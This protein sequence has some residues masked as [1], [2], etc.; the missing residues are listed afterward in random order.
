MGLDASVQN[1]A[2]TVN[3]SATAACT[4]VAPT[5]GN[6]VYPLTLRVV[7]SAGAPAVAE[8]LVNVARNQTPTL[9]NYADAMVGLNGMVQVT[10]SAPPADGND[11]FDAMMVE[12]A[13]LPN[14]GTVAVDPSGVV[15][16][17]AGASTPLG[18]YTIRVSA[19]DTC[20]ARETRQFTVTISDGIFE[21]GFE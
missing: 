20:G 11:N 17:S 19:V 4:L 21:D 13:T 8:V 6:R 12:P 14:G 2:G 5:S 1:I 16:V 10:P 18:D 9:G 15:T 3:L 7:D